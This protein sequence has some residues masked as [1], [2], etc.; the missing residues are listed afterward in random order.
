MEEIG[1]SLWK[2]NSSKLV[3]NS[4]VYEVNETIIFTRKIYSPI[5]SEGLDTLINTFTISENSSNVIS[6]KSS[7]LDGVSFE[8]YRSIILGEIGTVVINGNSDLVI[9]L[10]R[11]VGLYKIVQSGNRWAKTYELIQ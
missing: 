7:I 8:R 4:K 5:Y 11:S 3:G 2:I 9:S 1:E 10:K 6:F